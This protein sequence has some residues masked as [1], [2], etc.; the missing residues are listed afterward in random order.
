MVRKLPYVV[1]ACVDL[2]AFPTHTHGLTEIGMPEFIMDPLTFGPIGN[3]HIIN[4]AYE[5][6]KERKNARYLKAIFNG[7]TIKLTATELR[8]KHFMDDPYTYCFREVH[9][10]FEAVKQAYLIPDKGLEPG[11]RF[12]QIWV[13]GDDFALMDEYYR[14]GITW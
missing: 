2:P 4:A 14:Y 12:I 7:K 1:H 9:P 13:D 5:F 10:Q 6:L 8:P 3:M 11:M